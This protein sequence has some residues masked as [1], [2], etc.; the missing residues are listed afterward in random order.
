MGR[1]TRSWWRRIV[2]AFRSALDGPASCP[3]PLS[4]TTD[5]DFR[6]RGVVSIDA[7]SGKLEWRIVHPV[8]AWGIACCRGSGKRWEL[9]CGFCLHR[10][11]R[12]AVISVMSFRKTAERCKTGHR[13]E[14]VR[15]TGEIGGELDER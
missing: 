3:S 4:T 9:I 13:Y 5:T 8:R 6:K 14:V 10:T 7:S 12:E 2:G 15:M 11:K 1:D